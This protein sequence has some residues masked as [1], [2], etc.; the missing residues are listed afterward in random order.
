MS[1]RTLL[2]GVLSMGWAIGFAAP[3]QAATPS[4]VEAQIPLGSVKGRIDHLTIDEARGRLF[5]AESGNGTVGVVDLTQG[6]ALAQI[7][8]LREPHDAGK[9]TEP[10]DRQEERRGRRD[11]DAGHDGQ[12][13]GHCVSGGKPSL[14]LKVFARHPRIACSA[15]ASFSVCSPRSS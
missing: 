12:G 15:S 3:L 6:K 4:A 10:D 13:I 9:H 8:G 1:F 14:A 7:A 5:V 2:A 11:R